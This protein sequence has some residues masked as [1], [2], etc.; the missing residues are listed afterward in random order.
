MSTLTR[1]AAETLGAVIHGQ[2]FWNGH[3]GLEDASA[4]TVI[5]DYDGDVFQSRGN[6]N[7]GF[8]TGTQSIWTSGAFVFPVT[9]VSTPESTSADEVSV[10]TQNDLVVENIVIHNAE[11]L[12]IRGAL[13]WAFGHHA[14]LV[15]ARGVAAHCVFQ[16]WSSHQMDHQWFAFHS[17]EPIDFA[18]EPRRFPVRIVY[19][20]PC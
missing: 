11:E 15:D 14:V 6:D 5:V 2:D 3:T 7:W 19:P 20:G 4:G 8:I 1:L 10:T 16:D 12:R 13:D 9:V 18:A 17:T